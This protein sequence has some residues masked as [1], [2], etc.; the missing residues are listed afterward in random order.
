MKVFQ[1]Y[2]GALHEREAAARRLAFLAHSKADV[3]MDD[4]IANT[5]NATP[6]RAQSQRRS[7]RSSGKT[8]GDES[9]GKPALSTSSSTEEIIKKLERLERRVSNFLKFILIMLQFIPHP[10]L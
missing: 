1:D 4:S 5:E 10:S 8:A 9:T 2:W 3:T 7:L 6:S